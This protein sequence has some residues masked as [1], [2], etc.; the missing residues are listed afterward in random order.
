MSALHDRLKNNEFFKTGAFI[1]GKWIT[2]GKTFP[3]TNPATGERL[4]DVALE[5]PR[6]NGSGHHFGENGVFR[7]AENDRGRTG[8][9]S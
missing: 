4:A 9:P 5:R 6:G 1:H 2:T 8:P 3:D 7:L